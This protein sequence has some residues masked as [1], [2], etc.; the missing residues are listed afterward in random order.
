MD[1]IVKLFLN[2]NSSD[3]TYNLDIKILI[4]NNN[5]DNLK[6]WIQKSEL[7][8][9]KLMETVEICYGTIVK[10]LIFKDGEKIN[11]KIY[12]KKILQLSEDLLEKSKLSWIAVCYSTTETKMNES[13]MKSDKITFKNNLSFQLDDLPNVNI[14]ISLLK[15]VNKMNK[16]QINSLGTIKRNMFPKDLSSL[17]FGFSDIWDI[18]DFVSLYLSV[19]SKYRFEKS[20][21]DQIICVL[22]MIDD[23]FK[24]ESDGSY[25]KL[26]TE[27]MT[28]MHCNYKINDYITNCISKIFPIDS[29]NTYNIILKNKNK[30]LIA[31]KIKGKRCVVYYDSKKRYIYILSDLLQK[32]ELYDENNENYKLILDAEIVNTVN[33]FEIYVCDVIF[34]KISLMKE[35]YS[36][37]ID[38]I[39]EIINKMNILVKHHDM[40][41]I[42]KKRK[43]MNLCEIDNEEK[44]KT[45]MHTETPTEGNIIFEKSGKSYI[46]MIS[47][48]WIP[49]EHLRIN[50]SV[51]INK[52]TKEYEL[53][54]LSKNKLIKFQTYDNRRLY[55][56][57]SPQT[58]LKDGDV[59]SL[60][61]KN[62]QWKLINI[63][64][65]HK[66]HDI[67]TAELI[68]QQRK[69][70]IDISTI[71]YDN[72]DEVPEIPNIN[73]SYIFDEY[74]KKKNKHIWLFMNSVKITTSELQKVINNVEINHQLYI[75]TSGYTETYVV[76]KL[77]EKHIKNDHNKVK[78]CPSLRK[79]LRIY[80]NSNA[81]DVKGINMNYNVE[82]IIITNNSRF[83]ISSNL[84]KI[85]AF[86]KTYMIKYGRLIFVGFRFNEKEL[87]MIE[88]KKFLLEL[89]IE[90]K[91]TSF[92]LL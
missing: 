13:I 60:Q 62:K 36:N 35:S 66:P 40:N 15:N 67:K 72:N 75:F 5:I 3:T 65:K 92:V 90:N 50:F 32:I 87:M 29:I 8:N 88:K 78:I 82:I 27:I 22:D 7:R 9:A 6:K 51:N 85:I 25:S 38:S 68:W 83:D 45:L 77:Y 12:N 4:N 54:V 24:T 26:A 18:C 39:N 61:W 16:T 42:F 52:K 37:R 91:L 70:Y 47:Y 43:T 21:I 44:Y 71:L 20:L 58:N 2:K 80:K 46:N 33:N 86:A 49:K 79:I 11:E 59:C 17:A 74:L 14:N 56:Y 55:L 89:D 48:M 64:E 23:I 28:I 57:K 81:L 34:Y 69:N 31:P 53:M 63:S 76:K 19:N 84:S 1:N 10:T 30:Y 41:I 73:I